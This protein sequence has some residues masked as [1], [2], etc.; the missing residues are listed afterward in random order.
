MSR[1]ALWRELLKIGLDGDYFYGR[2]LWWLRRA[3]DWLLG[4]PS[5]RRRRRHPAELRVGDTVDSWRVIGLTEGERLTLLMEMRA[6]GAGVLEFEIDQ[7]G[8]GAR[9]RATAYWHPSGAWGLA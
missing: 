1:E 8:E 3:L 4:G 6:P 2:A 9:V 5:F 7:A